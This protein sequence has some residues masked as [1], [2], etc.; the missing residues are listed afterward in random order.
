MLPTC[1]KCGMKQEGKCVAGYNACFGCVKMDQNIRYFPW[2][3]NNE[4]DN[5]IRYQPNTLSSSSGL[6][7]NSPN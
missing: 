4:G 6:G 3:S 7:S 5:I 2:V 1:A